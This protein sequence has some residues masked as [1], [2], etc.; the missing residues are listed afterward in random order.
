MGEEG[1]VGQAGFVWQAGEVQALLVV[2]MELH[3]DQ[4]KP[5]LSA[6]ALVMSGR[7]R[8]TQ[9][10]YETRCAS[11]LVLGF[12]GRPLDISQERVATVL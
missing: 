3:Q 7:S 2:A 4:E 9:E 12:P 10:F 8:E 5:C 1:L 11:G 6:A